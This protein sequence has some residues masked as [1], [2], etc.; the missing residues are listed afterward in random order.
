MGTGPIDGYHVW[1]PA[2]KQVLDGSVKS[3][4]GSLASLDGNYGSDQH[5]AMIFDLALSGGGGGGLAFGGAATEA[6]GSSGFRGP[7]ERGDR[8]SSS[9]SASASSPGRQR[10]K[11]R[12]RNHADSLSR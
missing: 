5:R 11:R 4:F 8:R 10:N 3:S 12:Q 9:S 2:R 7:L 6:G 1:V